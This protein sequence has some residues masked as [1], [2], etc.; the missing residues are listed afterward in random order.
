MAQTLTSKHGELGE[1]ALISARKG[2]L[3]TML[4]R[5]RT[6]TVNVLCMALFG[7]GA[8][9]VE[10][11]W[12]FADG[13]SSAVLSA[14]NIPL[15]SC[16]VLSGMLFLRST[17]T[18]RRLYVRPATYLLAQSGA[19]V[20]WMSVSSIFYYLIIGLLNLPYL[21]KTLG[22]LFGVLATPVVIAFNG[23]PYMGLAG[24]VTGLLCGLVLIRRR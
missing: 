9:G 2:A 4:T 12:N 19:G 1:G 3:S 16:G 11:L 8:V 10:A 24:A 17:P 6:F 20:V 22:T 21:P 14:V 5:A 23:L 15:I 7:L 18:A 13:A